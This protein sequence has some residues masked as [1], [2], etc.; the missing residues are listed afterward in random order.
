M[1][2]GAQQRL[3]A[4][5]GSLEGRGSLGGDLGTPVPASPPLPRAPSRSRAGVLA[6]LLPNRA[7]RPGKR[8]PAGSLGAPQC[9][10]EPR[11]CVNLPKQKPGAP[12]ARAASHR[13]R[14]LSRGPPKG[15]DAGHSVCAAATAATLCKT[16]CQRRPA[17]PEGFGCARARARVLQSRGKSHLMH[18]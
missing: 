3:S 13:C 16:C 11:R 4:V 18:T 1:V 15:H 17:A 2:V 8:G 10:R 6:S 5:T 12:G 7:S 9:L 14:P